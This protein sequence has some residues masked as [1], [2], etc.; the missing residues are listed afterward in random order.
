M[1]DIAPHPSRH[2]FGDGRTVVLDW[3]FAAWLLQRAGL[4][5]LRVRVRGHDPEVDAQLM[6]LTIAGLNW[7][8]SVNGNNSRKPAEITPPS[9]W[10]NTQEVATVLNVGESRIRQLLRA[11]DIKGEQPGRTWRIHR[12]ELEH[13]R[14]ARK[15]TA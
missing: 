12:T 2:L 15:A 1:T 14:A 13:Y 6:A 10:M 9:E 7:A 5:E 8:A 3:R 4:R 11:G